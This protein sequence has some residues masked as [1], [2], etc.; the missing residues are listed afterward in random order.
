L[1]LS[2]EG[3]R[4]TLPRGE[5]P[6]L[7]FLLVLTSA[8]AAFDPP[9][10][11]AQVLPA[12]DDGVDNDGDGDIDWYEDATCAD[13]PAG[14]SEGPPA[15]CG[16]GVDNDGDGRVDRNDPGCR[17]RATGTD[18]TDPGPV[19][20]SF[21]F[22]VVRPYG[23]GI[24][25]AVEV[26]P[27]LT[28]LRLFPFADVMIRVRGVAGKARG[29]D[30]TRLLPVA[31]DPGYVFGRLK[32]GRFNVTGSYVGDRFRLASGTVTRRLRLSPK[33]CLVYVS[34]SGSRRYKPRLLPLGA[35]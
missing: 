15:V 11:V 14:T 33:R 4:T 22:D 17:G 29:I 18:E 28:P 26:L 13:N 23:C 34:G 2:P 12:C 7:V 8:A 6:A 27:D 25:T 35:S 31:A 16:D 10:A 32:P 30:K 24:E 21:G 3:A 9:V 5:R 19:P 20:S 1:L